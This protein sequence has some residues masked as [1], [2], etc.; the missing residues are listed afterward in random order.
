MIINKR[1]HERSNT[2]YIRFIRQ[3]NEK[4]DIQ[5]NESEFNTIVQSVVSKMNYKVVKA[6]VN[7]FSVDMYQKSN[8]GKTTHQTSYKFDKNTG[9]AV[10]T[11][12]AYPD[13]TVPYKFASAITNRIRQEL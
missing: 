3:T 8:S 6:D 2:L 13:S 11:F 5:M 7:G 10:I 1:G 9:D 12:I 4:R